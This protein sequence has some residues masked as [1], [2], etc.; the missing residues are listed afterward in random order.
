[1]SRA[2][3]HRA[4]SDWGYQL[5]LGGASHSDKCLVAPWDRPQMLSHW[6]DQL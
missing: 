5:E 6:R 1:M 4:R 3:G 2:I